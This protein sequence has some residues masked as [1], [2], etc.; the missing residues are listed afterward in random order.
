MMA[1][2]LCAADHWEAARKRVEAE[3]GYSK[4]SREHRAIVHH[5]CNMSKLDLMPHED[6][7]LSGQDLS[8]HRSGDSAF[9]RHSFQVGS[10]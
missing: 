3:Q 6:A 9:G 7:N 4:A 5:V 2:V 1:C 8:A 10:F